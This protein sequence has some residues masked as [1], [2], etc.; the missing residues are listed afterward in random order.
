MDLATFLTLLR[1]TAA[2]SIPTIERGSTKEC[3]KIRYILDERHHCP[4]TL[5]CS[6][7]T[8]VHYPLD[9]WPEAARA[10]GLPDADAALVASAADHTSR[11]WLAERDARHEWLRRAF[12]ATLH[13]KGGDA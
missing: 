5:V 13:K 10:L 7:T 12:A 2:H 4:L 6:A 9:E 1:N 8:G 11:C 3:P